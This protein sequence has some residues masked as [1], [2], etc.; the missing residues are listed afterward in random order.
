[1]LSQCCYAVSSVH[2]T[3]DSSILYHLSL[4]TYEVCMLHLEEGETIVTHK[5]Q[6]TLNS[7]GF[8]L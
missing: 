2:G 3:A 8:M 6:K 4:E 7:S 1:M 5:I